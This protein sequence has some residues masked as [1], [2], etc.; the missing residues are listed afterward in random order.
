MF[1]TYLAELALDSDRV[2]QRRR[3]EYRWRD[4][5]YGWMAGIVGSEIGAVPRGPSLWRQLLDRVIRQRLPHD[6]TLHGV[7]VAE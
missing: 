5:E 3:D 2:L 6:P 7:S 4:P 1:D